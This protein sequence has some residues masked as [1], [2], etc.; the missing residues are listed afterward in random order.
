MTG[1]IPALPAVCLPAAR[2]LQLFDAS[3]DALCLFDRAGR[4]L[5]VSAACRAL[6][7]YAP[8]DLIGR[9]YL[10]LV[11]P[12]DQAATRATAGALRHGAAVSAFENRCRRADGT[13]IAIR[14]SASRDEAEGI[15]YA[16]ARDAGALRRQQE[17]EEELRRSNERF[18]LAARTDAIYDWDLASGRLHWGEGLRSIFGY[19]ES[20]LQLA[21]WIDALHPSERAGLEQ[22]LRAALDNPATDHWAAEYQLRRPDGSWS[23]VHEKG[24]ILRDAAGSATRMVGR[25]EDITGRKHR[26]TELRKLSLITEQT[27]DAIVV[28]NAQKETTWVNAA[29]TRLTGYSLA[30]MLGRR[31]AA[32][33]E[34]PRPDAQL[35][36]RVEEEYRHKRPF[37]LEALNYRKDGSPFWSL[38]SI[39]PVLDAEGNVLE[40]F[41]IRKDITE[42]KRL[43]QQLEQQ[44]QL[45]T[46]AVIAAQEKERSDMSRELH[47]NVNQ[48][49]TTV[50]LYQELAL[51]GFGDRDELAR[52]SMRLLQES[53]NEIRSISKRLSAPSLGTIR[54]HESVRELADAVTATNRLQVS[55]DTAAI[56]GYD[57]PRETHIAL[58]RMLQEQLTNVLKHAGAT[59]VRI[60][61][62]L[63]PQ[64][65]TMEVRDDGCGFH[66]SARH[67]GT[68]L[69]NIRSRAEGLGG[70]VQVESA[71]G[72]GCTLRVTLPAAQTHPLTPSQREGE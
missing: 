57:C 4:F 61:F 36:A 22:S 72:Q 59:E 37:T 40:Y 51:S 18:R 34:G 1:P 70:T 2:L 48:V 33:L 20:E 47:D 43:E 66:P 9:R 55:L 6:W 49:L 17:A 19:E 39:E 56:A 11:H 23:F 53:I 42:R 67:A 41:S 29:F 32:L 12:D 69:S 10:Y 7:G 25:I 8:E 15:V 16:I 58:Y 21:Q 14:W 62:S 30:D 35:L 28:T 38:I 46:A 60:R 26:E 31:P 63:S 71:P 13:L 64:E 44:R 45:M 27:D 5:A 24:Y 3:P 52:K 50:K 68:G 65:L 54:L